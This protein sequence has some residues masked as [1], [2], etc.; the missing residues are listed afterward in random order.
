MEIGG[1]IVIGFYLK[2]HFVFRFSKFCSLFCFFV[3][4]VFSFDSHASEID[5]KIG[6]DDVLFI[7]VYEELDLTLEVRVSMDGL[8]TYP[9]LGRVQA[10]GLTIQ[11]LEK[12]ITDLLEKDYLVHPQVNIVIRQYSKVYVVGGVRAPGLY[13]LKP[14]IN[15]MTVIAMAGG[16]SEG[17]IEGSVLVIRQG[18][19]TKNVLEIPVSELVNDAIRDDGIKLM[20]NDIIQVK[21]SESGNIYVLGQVGRP[22]EYVLKQDTTVVEAVTMAGGLTKIAA[23]NRIRVIRNENGSK[24]VIDVPVGDI[25]K[26]GDKSKD[27]I[28]KP[29]D[30]VMVPESF[31]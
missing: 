26:T 19:D 31:F 3:F 28:L 30:V 29:N 21:N 5:Y 24:Q 13:E 20:A 18:S 1:L 8:I 7:S 11:E 16:L 9:L 15:L 22:G 12:K 6:P 4:I 27:I 10:S 2:R 17:L 23:A 25:L 14:G